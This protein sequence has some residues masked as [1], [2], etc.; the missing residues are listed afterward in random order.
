MLWSDEYPIWIHPDLEDLLDINYIV[1]A[2]RYDFATFKQIEDFSKI[3]DYFKLREELDKLEWTTPAHPQDRV[4]NSR[5][6]KFEGLC[7]SVFWGPP[8]FRSN[9]ASCVI[10][11]SKTVRERKDLERMNHLIDEQ[12]FRMN[13]NPLLSSSK[14]VHSWGRGTP[15]KYNDWKEFVKAF[16]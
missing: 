3:D 9:H 1:P 8:E 7:H 14:I 11:H 6:V 13:I 12:F 4:Y 5:Y 2:M 10:L 16:E 15:M